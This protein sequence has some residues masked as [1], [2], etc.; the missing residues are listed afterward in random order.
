VVE[1]TPNRGIFPHLWHAVVAVDLLKRAIVEEVDEDGPPQASLEQ[2]TVPTR[3]AK[4]S[5]SLSSSLVPIIDLTEEAE[6]SVISRCRD[7]NTVFRSAGLLRDHIHRKHVRRFRCTVCGPEMAFN[8]RADLE[9]H[10]RAKHKRA[11]AVLGYKCKEVGCSMPNKVWER[12][13][14]IRRHVERCRRT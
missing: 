9:R 12:K 5:S 6:N 13:D 10:R 11:S 1:H 3:Q 14:N 8:L 7:C 2:E 4:E